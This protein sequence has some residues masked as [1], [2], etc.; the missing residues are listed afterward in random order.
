VGSGRVPDPFKPARGALKGGVTLKSG[1]A[2]TVTLDIPDEIAR[3][4]AAA[5]QEI[6]WAALEALAIE[7]YR[8]GTLTQAHVGRLLGLSRI[9]TEDFLAQHVVLYDYDPAELR[10]EAEVLA[11]LSDR[12]R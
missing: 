1:G 4:L 12:P 6:S 3:E 5:G 8:R 2:T 11:K 9:Q 10:R 7:G